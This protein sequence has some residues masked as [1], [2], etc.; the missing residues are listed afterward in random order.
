MN[1][2]EPARRVSPATCEM[3]V[4]AKAVENDDE[5]IV[6]PAVESSDNLAVDVAPAAKVEPAVTVGDSRKFAPE[7]MLEENYRDDSLDIS[8]EKLRVSGVRFEGP[9]GITKGLVVTITRKTLGKILPALYDD[10]DF[11]SYGEM[12]RYIAIQDHTCFVYPSKSEPSLLY[13]IP[14]STLKPTI[15]DP[16]NPHPRSLTVSPNPITN[17]QGDG[18]ETVLLLDARG[19]LAFQLTFDLSKGKSLAEDFVAA[20]VESNMADKNM[21]KK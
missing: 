6:E 19:K 1:L 16:K 13:T 12:E 21:E 10:R 2:A 9:V 5:Y 7:K 20:V 14:I 11:I 3:S 8:L 17:L 18:L 4:A 15:E